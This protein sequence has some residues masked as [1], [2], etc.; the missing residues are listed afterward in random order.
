MAT[1]SSVVAFLIALLVAPPVTRGEAPSPQEIRSAVEQSLPLIARSA[2]EY[3]GHRD[4]FSCHHQALPV[5]ALSPAKVGLKPCGNRTSWPQ[6]WPPRQ[7][8]PRI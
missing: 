2:K 1:G 6:L 7:P 8:S 4:C 3:T 5:V